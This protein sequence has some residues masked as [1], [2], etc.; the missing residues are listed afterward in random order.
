MKGHQHNIIKCNGKNAL[1]QW[2]KLLVPAPRLLLSQWEMPTWT[3][4][5]GVGS[6]HT[7]L[8]DVH[9]AGT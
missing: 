7:L 2:T 6:W 1:T 9:P 5:Q 3:D 8:L 4:F